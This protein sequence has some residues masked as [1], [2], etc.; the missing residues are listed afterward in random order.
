MSEN[1][2]TAKTA[3]EIALDAKKKLAER[4]ESDVDRFKKIDEELNIRIAAGK[5]SSLQRKSF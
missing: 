5:E 3:I 2:K 1:A 4:A